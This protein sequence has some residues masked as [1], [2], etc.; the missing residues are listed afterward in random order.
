MALEKRKQA[1]QAMKESR[2][3]AAAENIERNDVLDNLL[4]KLRNGEGVN[5]K[6]RRTRGGAGEM[7]PVVP[8]TLQL[9]DG[10]TGDTVDIARD[11]LAQLQS[12]GFVA[13]TPSPTVPTRPSSRRRTRR[14]M[15]AASEGALEPKSPLSTELELDLGSEVDS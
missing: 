6:S 13:P 11:M 8:L 1:A 5:R 3:K 4:E 2:E 10:A 9:D 12:N 15:E 14:R 7:Q